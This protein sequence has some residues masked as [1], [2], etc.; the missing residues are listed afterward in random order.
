[1]NFACSAASRRPSEFGVRHALASLFAT[2]ELSPIACWP[3]PSRDGRPLGGFGGGVIGI[4][5]GLDGAAVSYRPGTQV[6]V[7]SPH[8]YGEAS[9]LLV[10]EA[11]RGGLG[12]LESRCADLLV[13]P[14]IDRPFAMPP[15]SA[16]KFLPAVFGFAGMRH[17]AALNN[18]QLFEDHSR[19]APERPWE[20]RQNKPWRCQPCWLARCRPVRLG[21]PWRSYIPFQ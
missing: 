14:D 17:F 9:R 6:Q 12:A 21:S 10:S 18:R 20:A 2:A 4:V 5:A 19:S 7:V 1:M 11:R 13:L 8:Q 3:G 15:L 16:A